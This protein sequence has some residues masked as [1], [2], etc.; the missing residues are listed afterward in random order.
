MVLDGKQ[1]TKCARHITLRRAQI[2]VCIV[3]YS[4]GHAI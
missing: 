4:D 1:D 2:S 3:L